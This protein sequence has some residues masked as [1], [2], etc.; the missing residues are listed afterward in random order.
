MKKKSTL[1]R[2]RAHKTTETEGEHQMLCAF[3]KLP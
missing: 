3:S 2:G 1:T